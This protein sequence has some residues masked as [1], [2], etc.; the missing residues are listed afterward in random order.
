MS[1]A[2]FVFRNCKTQKCIHFSLKASSSFFKFQ[3][4]FFQPDALWPILNTYKSKIIMNLRFLVGSFHL[5]LLIETLFLEFPM[6]K[7]VLSVLM[8]CAPVVYRSDCRY[9]PYSIHFSE[10]MSISLRENG[11][12][13]KI[14]KMVAD[15]YQARKA[16]I[17]RELLQS[18]VLE[19]T[20]VMLK[21][22]QH[23]PFKV[24]SFPR[25]SFQLCITRVNQST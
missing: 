25:F 6:I 19:Q 5:L 1:V 21:N 17:L 12:N 18:Y 4:L 2:Y 20:E 24:H 22:G 13:T 23:S 10:F 15:G 7:E 8:L 14:L 16:L 11:Q 3:F 9:L